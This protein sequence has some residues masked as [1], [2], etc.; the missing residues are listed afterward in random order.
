MYV[1]PEHA[2]KMSVFLVAPVILPELAFLD[3]I[4]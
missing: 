2:V 4:T 3:V 1:K